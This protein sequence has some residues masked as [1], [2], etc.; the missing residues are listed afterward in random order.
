M[1]RSGKKQAELA[2]QKEGS[3]GY[4]QAMADLEALQ[5]AHQEYSE[6]L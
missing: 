5:A 6:Q 4:Q 2:K 3:K 1:N